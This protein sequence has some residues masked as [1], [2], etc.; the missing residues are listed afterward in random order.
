MENCLSFGF[1][2]A[3]F[4]MTNGVNAVLSG[5]EYTFHEIQTR[6]VIRQYMVSLAI[7]LVLAFL[8]LMTVG[9]YRSYRIFYK[10]IE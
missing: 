5:F 1:I 8:L 7:S 6:T 10:I 3:I 2:L 4:L 9:D